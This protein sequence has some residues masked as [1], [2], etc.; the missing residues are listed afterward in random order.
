MTDTAVVPETIRA[1][2]A[3]YYAAKLED[4]RIF[5]VVDRL[6]DRFN[7]GLLPIGRDRDVFLQW[8]L[9]RRSL[10]EVE[11][12]RLYARTLGI[13]GGDTAE[14]PNREFPELWQRFLAAVAALDRSI[15][16]RGTKYP[17]S[18]DQHQV[19]AAARALAVHLSGSSDSAAP[20]RDV[21]RQTGAAIAVLSD[22]EIQAA[23]GVRDVA[24]VID[25]VALTEFGG[26]RNS[27]RTLTVANSA[28]TV[29]AW[30]AKR[31]T[32]V[33]AGSPADLLDMADRH[34]SPNATTDPTDADLVLACEQWLAVTAVDDDD[35]EGL[36]QPPSPEIRRAIDELLSRSE[37]FS[38]LAPE[39][40]EGIARDTARVTAA[41]VAALDFPAFVASVIEGV[42]EAIVGS[43]IEQM[44]A[45]GDL[46]AAVVAAL[47]ALHAKNVTEAQA[48]DH[49]AR[50]FP[51]LF[52]PAAAPCDLTRLPATRY[53]LLARLLAT[54]IIRLVAIPRRHS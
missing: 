28:V 46:I 37:A 27:A 26:A 40:R 24:G 13:P 34:R 20:A 35:V 54:G 6:V 15:A 22:R 48:R 39:A 14:T 11:R 10:S 36:A 51:E 47:D 3:L 38:R 7:Q 4:L 44:E 19:K 8:S 32:V 5:D 43:S 33:S 16:A 18:V 1:L 29:F 25:S 9:V 23:Y 17:Q 41:L 45:Y 2:G 53:S 42:F 21:Q 12:R 50:R 31:S 30:L 49:I 52:P